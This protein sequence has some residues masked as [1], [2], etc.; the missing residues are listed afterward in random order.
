MANKTLKIKN[1][2]LTDIEKLVLYPSTEQVEQFNAKYGDEIKFRTYALPIIKSVVQRQLGLNATQL[3][4]FQKD[5]FKRTGH[6][7]ES[8]RALRGFSK[9]LIQK[10][11]AFP[12]PPVSKKKSDV[13]AVTGYVNLG[14]TKEITKEVSKLPKGIKVTKAKAKTQ[15]K[16]S[17]PTPVTDI[18]S[19]LNSLTE[20]VAQVTKSLT[21][22]AGVV[23]KIATK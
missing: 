11:Q 21:E 14:Y 19:Q 2:T 6:K 8:S 13:K 20:T 1:V 17:N 12:V 10:E 4:A 23:S 7:I 15:K 22:L 18:Q 5:H 3:K 9:S 16:S